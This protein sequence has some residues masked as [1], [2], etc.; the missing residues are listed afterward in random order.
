MSFIKQAAGAQATKNNKDNGCKKI[1][2]GDDN[3]DNDNNN[4]ND[5]HCNNDNEAAADY[6]SDGYDSNDNNYD[7]PNH[8]GP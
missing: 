6:N 3:N 8:F 5:E 7:F 1:I 2:D 4:S